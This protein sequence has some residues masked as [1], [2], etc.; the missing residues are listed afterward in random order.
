MYVVITAIIL[1]LGLLFWDTIKI[2]L[3]TMTNNS[4]DNGYL[5]FF[6]LLGI[7]AIIITFILWFYHYKI[8]EPGNTGIDGSTG[9]TGLP[10]NICNIDTPCNTTDE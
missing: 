2:M 8:N 9:N 7:N 5:W 10:G 4:L 3:T 6:C 1:I